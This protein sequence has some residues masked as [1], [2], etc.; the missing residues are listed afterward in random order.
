MS[1]SDLVKVLNYHCSVDMRRGACLGK[2]DCHF[3]SDAAQ[4]KLNCRVHRGNLGASLGF[5][6]REDIKVI[7]GE[8]VHIWGLLGNLVSVVHHR[9][10]VHDRGILKKV[11]R[12]QEETDAPSWKRHRH[13]GHYTLGDKSEKDS[14]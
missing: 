13:Q 6:L 7:K 9:C 5:M 3:L 8:A 4:G 14:L 10:A 12:I 1:K 11:R 2:G